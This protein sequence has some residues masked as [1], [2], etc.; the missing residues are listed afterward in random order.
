MK[1]QLVSKVDYFDVKKGMTVDVLSFH[2]TGKGS[3]DYYITVV[4]G[5]TKQHYL[6]TA[7]VEK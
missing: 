3:C 5:T 7:E 2:E 1:K 6:Y 4:P